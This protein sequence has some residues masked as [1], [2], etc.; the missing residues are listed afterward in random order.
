MAAEINLMMRSLSALPIVIVM[1]AAVAVARLPVSAAGQSPATPARPCAGCGIAPEP[2]DLTDVAGWMRIFDGVSL[3]GWDGNP[4]VWKVENGAITAISTAE[5]RL[6]TTYAIWRGGE[7]SDFELKL[8]IKTDSDIHGGVFY[9]GKVGPNPPRPGATGRAVGRAAGT[10]TTPR[11]PQ[12]AFA[13]PADPKWNV[14]GYSLDFDY[15]RDNNGNVQ[16]TSGRQ[17]TQIVWRG[18]IV[19]M[20]PGKRPRSI[21]S[22]GDR[23]ALMEKMTSGEWTSLH[24]IARGNQ[25]THIVNGHVMAMLIDDDPAALKTKG[26]IAL[27]IEQYGLGRIS[28]RNIWLKQ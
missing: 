16:D 2:I 21:G 25:L 8:E 18:H 27:Q 28:F 26:V 9:R 12:P 14:T 22:L 4:D 10:G 20:E 7:P 13:I 1:T 15:A 5:R 6:G 24:I 23:D 11:P 19:R 3:E 17:E